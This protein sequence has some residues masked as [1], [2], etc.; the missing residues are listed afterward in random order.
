MHRVLYAPQA[1]LY[2]QAWKSFEWDMH[3]IDAGR[4]RKQFASEM[5][6]R[7]NA[8]RSVIKLSRAQARV[9]EEIGNAVHG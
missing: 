4:T 9:G 5:R 1:H 7:S 3:R 8:E 2:V 6:S